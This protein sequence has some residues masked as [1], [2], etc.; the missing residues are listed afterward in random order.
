MHPKE[1]K[2]QKWFSMIPRKTIT[3][4]G[5]GIG[6]LLLIIGAVNTG[7]SKTDKTEY[8]IRYYT[9]ELEERI[10]ELCTSING[11]SEATVLLTL[12]NGTEYVYA[13]NKES[14]GRA[15]DYVIVSSKE[16]EEAVLV[17]EIFP[18]IRGVAVVCTGGNTALVQQTIVNLLSASLGVPSTRI[19]VAGN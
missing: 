15:W 9:E 13:Q 18:Q 6:I 14:D 19:H 4:L 11:V 12:E 5:M 16:G 10:R 7:E 2:G 17:T 8:T 3:I 1:T